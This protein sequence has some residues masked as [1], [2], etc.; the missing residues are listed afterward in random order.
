M[1]QRGVSGQKGAS[2]TAAKTLGPLLMIW[3]HPSRSRPC[4]LTHYRLVK[5]IK[6]MKA[7][8][9]TLSARE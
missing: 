4:R 9:A 8:T 5:S 7:M 1:L 6:M 2:G 3:V